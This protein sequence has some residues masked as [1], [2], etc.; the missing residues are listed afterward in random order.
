[1]SDERTDHL[2]EQTVDSTSV[3]GIP[4][5]A[6][7][8][9]NR[10]DHL[11]ISFNSLNTNQLISEVQDIEAVNNYHKTLSLPQARVINDKRKR[12]IADAIDEFGFKDVCLGLE[13]MSKSKFLKEKDSLKWFDFDRVYNQ[14]TLCKAIE[15]KYDDKDQSQKQLEYVGFNDY[16]DNGED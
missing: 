1:L 14:D 15:G 7:L 12:L 6:H 5:T 13:K 16:Y 4:W 11:P 2:S 8:P 9:A 3:E 10:T